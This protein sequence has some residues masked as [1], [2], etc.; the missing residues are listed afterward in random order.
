MVGRGSSVRRAASGK[1]A[2]GLPPDEGPDD[3][4][5]RG[6][7][8]SI[9]L[10]P[11]TFDHVMYDQ[12]ADVVYLSIGEPRRA[13]GEETPEGHVALYDEATGE[14]CGLT[15]IGLQHLI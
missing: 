1:R 6:A 10:G 5:R 2:Y 13:I 3:R 4:P 11:W 9:R 12:D 8:M 7:A 15:L 14:L